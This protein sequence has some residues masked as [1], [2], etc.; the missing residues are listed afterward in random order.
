MYNAKYNISDAS[1]LN[2]YQKTM[3]KTSA[4]RRTDYRAH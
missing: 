2:E 4:G 1:Q 3:S